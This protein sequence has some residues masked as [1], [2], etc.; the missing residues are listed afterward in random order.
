MFTRRHLI[1]TA[2]STLGTA[3]LL[4]AAAPAGAQT[5]L[6]KPVKTVVGFPAG[7][8]ADSVARLLAEQLRGSYAPTVLVDNKPGAGGRLGAQTVKAAE[9]DGSVILLTPASI[10][11][12]YPH[13]YKKLGYDSL[14]DFTPVGSV[15]KV[16]FALSV[17]RAVPASVKTV[18]DY[19]AW[20]K[21]NPK[22]ANF[23]SPAAGATPHFVGTML[24]R[25]GG[26]PLN[27]IPFKGGAPL[28]ADL[29]GG[30]VQ[31]GVNVLPEV[32]P[33]APDGKLRILAVSGAKRSPFLPNVPTMAESGFKDV[34]AD[35]Y[36]GV[37]APAKTPPAVVARLNA[38]IRTA[39]KAK[40]MIAGLEKL[41]FEVAGE[42]APEFDKIV[43]DELV[44]WGP[45]VK[46][47]GFSSED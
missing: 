45:V 47:S 38:A 9:A 4:A 26:V 37:F 42:P 35:E 46:A 44:R 31:S 32:L 30:Q 17:S 6:N 23:G 27:H 41:S 1:T 10:L 18:S 24:A 34:A 14:A 22:D 21:A 11:T 7:G 15:A 33:H 39:L 2:L 12:I 29:L 5:V 13:V 43:R 40:P 28:V 8:A 25:A 16:T 36:F 20:A 3:T 19:V